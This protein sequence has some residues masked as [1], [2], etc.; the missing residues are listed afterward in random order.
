MGTCT[1]TSPSNPSNITHGFEG[2][3]PH[4]YEYG[5][6]QWYPWEY[7]C[8]CLDFIPQEGDNAV[9]F[10]N[11]SLLVDYNLDCLFPYFQSSLLISS[12]VS[13]LSIFTINN[14]KLLEKFKAAF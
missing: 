11:K 10:Q 7:L 9:N 12:H 4:R 6:A 2:M 3:Y 1:N 13:F 5:R 14:L 8:H